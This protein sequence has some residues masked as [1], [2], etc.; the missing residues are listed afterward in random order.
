MDEKVGGAIRDTLR[1]DDG[2]ISEEPELELPSSDALDRVENVQPLPKGWREMIDHDTKLPYYYNESKNMTSWDRP[3]SS[4]AQTSESS[5]TDVVSSDKTKDN[6]PDG[7]V[8]LFDENVQLPYYFNQIKNT[9]TWEKPVATNLVETND[10]KEDKTLVAEQ[11]E[12]ENDIMQSITDKDVSSANSVKRHMYRPPCAISSFGFGGRL[13]I[14][15]PQPAIALSGSKEENDKPVS[16]RK[17]DIAL[18]RLNDLIENDVLSL[19]STHTRP[20]IDTMDNDVFSYIEGEAKNCHDAQLEVNS[21]DYSKILWELILIAARSKGSFRSKLGTKD[22]SGPESAI[23]DLLLAKDND[24][25]S[26]DKVSSTEF[27][28]NDDIDI[29]GKFIFWYWLFIFILLMF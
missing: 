28:K 9:T 11:S 24:D 23:L 15:V 22:L 19:P 1:N 29:K 27:K 6:L 25:N 18:Y 2:F 26:H 13:C 5:V 8:E 4:T 3:D 17:G 7:W 10:L 20:L 14:M 16:W 21:H 12:M